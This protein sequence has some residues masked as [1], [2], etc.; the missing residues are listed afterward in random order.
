MVSDTVIPKKKN[1]KK[2]KQSDKNGSGHRLSRRIGLQSTTFGRFDL[3]KV[4]I[5]HVSTVF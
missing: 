5:E 4:V 2:K 1:N 3:T